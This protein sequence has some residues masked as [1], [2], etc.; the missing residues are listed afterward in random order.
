MN[1]VHLTFVLQVLNI[2]V[3]EDV[4]PEI[5]KNIARCNFLI[6]TVIHK[7]TQFWN[8]NELENPF[9]ITNFTKNADF[10]RKW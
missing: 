6:I 8:G 2:L 10:V 9:L 1:A 4:N 5:V 7:S 3:K